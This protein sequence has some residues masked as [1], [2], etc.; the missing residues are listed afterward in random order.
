MNNKKLM[1]FSHF[2][3]LLFGTSLGMTI[4][5]LYKSIKHNPQ[6]VTEVF[7][8]P[9]IFLVIISVILRIVT[10]IIFKKNKKEINCCK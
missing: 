8:F 2:I 4:V 7:L 1:Y 10:I 9:I 5:F 3:S 6:S